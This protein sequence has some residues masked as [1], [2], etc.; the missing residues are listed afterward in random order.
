MMTRNE[1]MRMDE[2]KVQMTPKP[3][4]KIKQNAES[5]LFTRSAKIEY[6]K[7]KPTRIT[8]VA[9]GSSYV[10]TEAKDAGPAKKSADCLSK[11][12]HAATLLN[13]PKKSKCRRKPKTPKDV[14]EAFFNLKKTL[15]WNVAP[16]EPKQIFT[17]A[18]EK[19]LIEKTFKP[20]EPVPSR[21]KYSANKRGEE[22][23]GK[24]RWVTVVKSQTKNNMP[25]P[26]PLSRRKNDMG[27]SE[28]QQIMVKAYQTNSH[29][30]FVNSR[31]I[32]DTKL[33]DDN[34]LMI[35]K[36]LSVKS[37]FTSLCRYIN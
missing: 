3:I 21:E 8:K 19:E 13:T 30:H 10:I 16:T 33:R 12:Y 27:L 32:V 4:N 6:E 18:M 35:D 28:S 9:F 7:P 26:P 20:E 2:V 31:R 36:L 29:S 17:R 37:S 14:D 5:K 15:G 11:G 34:R 25:P 1:K 24:P 22:L 23:Y